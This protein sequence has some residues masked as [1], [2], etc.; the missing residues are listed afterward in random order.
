MR[1]HSKTKSKNMKLITEALEEFKNKN[2]LIEDYKVLPNGFLI[3][4]YPLSSEEKEIYGINQIEKE[5]HLYC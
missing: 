2:L 5:I 3:K 4:F 1:L